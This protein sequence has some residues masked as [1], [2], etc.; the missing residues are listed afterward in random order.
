MHRAGEIRRAPGPA[1]VKLWAY[2]RLLRDEG[3]NFRRQHALGPYIT[4]FCSPRQKLIIEV[5]GSQHL[6]QIQY[7]SERTAFL[8]NMG[9]R[10]VRFYNS[11]VMNRIEMVME[12]IRQELQLP[13]T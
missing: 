12:F 8:E 9:Y 3:Y 5:D 4:D 10:V 11:D 1:E 7:D 2:L 13:K 6:T